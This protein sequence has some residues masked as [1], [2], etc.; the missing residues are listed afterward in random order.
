MTTPKPPRRLPPAD[1]IPVLDVDRIFRAPWEPR[2][3]PDGTRDP[4]LPFWTEFWKDLTAVVRRRSRDD[5]SQ[6]R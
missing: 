6:K 1:E 5:E 4:D 3:K 2:T